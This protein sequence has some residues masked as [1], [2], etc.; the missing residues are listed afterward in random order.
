VTLVSNEEGKWTRLFNEI[1]L[2]AES[3]GVST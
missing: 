2:I 1:T 3:Y